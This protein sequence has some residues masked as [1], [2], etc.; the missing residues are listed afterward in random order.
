MKDRNAF[1]V[2]ACLHLGLFLFFTVSIGAN[3]QLRFPPRGGGGMISIDLTQDQKP[4]SQSKQIASQPKP[5]PT[6]PKIVPTKPKPEPTEEKPKPEPTVIKEEPTKPKPEPEKP[7]KL[8]DETIKDLQKKLKEPTPTVKKK[9][10]PTP[11]P[12]SKAPK[13]TKTPTPEDKAVPDEPPE[14][15]RV[16]LSEIQKQL[17]SIIQ[18][19][20][21]AFKISGDPDAPFVPGDPNSP[22]IEGDP[23]APYDFYGYGS[24]LAR[25]L[26]RSWEQPSVLPPER[27]EFTTFASFVI[28]RD[29]TISD[30]VIKPSG[31][32]VLDESV[33]AAIEKANPVEPLPFEYKANSIRVNAP[34]IMPLE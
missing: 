12:R 23:N 5:V 13:P 32:P 30:I 26:Y 1:I 19:S 17:S 16:P 22:F 25:Q 8:S 27:K 33:R 6:Q 11:T 7:K 24:V 29:G 20:N 3:Y 31:W 18:E 14:V 34:F 15:T 10:T 2:S 4:P 28:S 21:G 9:Q